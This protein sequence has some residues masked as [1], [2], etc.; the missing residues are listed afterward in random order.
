MVEEDKK[1]RARIKVCKSTN[2][3][4]RKRPINNKA[5]IKEER[6]KLTDE[7]KSR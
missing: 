1:R 2:E 5:I 7:E 6:P 3:N 4:I